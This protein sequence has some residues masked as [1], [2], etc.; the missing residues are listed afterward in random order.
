[1]LSGGGFVL[2]PGGD[3]RK[4]LAKAS[5]SGLEARWRD[6]NGKVVQLGANGGFMEVSGRV[7][8]SSTLDFALSSEHKDL[9]AM[10]TRFADYLKLRGTMNF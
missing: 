7:P 2:G 6:A 4:T 1:M 10:P 9:E 8:G 3:F 5:H